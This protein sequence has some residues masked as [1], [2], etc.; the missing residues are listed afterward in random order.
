MIKIHKES[1]AFLYGSL[2]YLASDYNLIGYV[3]FCDRDH[4]I[5][6]VNNNDHEIER[7]FS[8]WESGI[9]KRCQVEQI[10]MTD[11]TGYTTKV[12]PHSVLA[13]KLKLKLPKT[14][15]T[16]LRHREELH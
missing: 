15:V 8:V 12:M 14:S 3:R 4:Y 2:K 11:D 6:I 7:E 9:P 1:N 5:I 13:G 10:M 16:I